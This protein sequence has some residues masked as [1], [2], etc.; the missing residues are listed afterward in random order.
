[1]KSAAAKKELSSA[2]RERLLTA[3]KARF[4]KN[5]N[6]HKGLDWAGVQAKLQANPKKL[7]SLQEME[8]TGGEPDVAT[9]DAQ[10]AS[11]SVLVNQGSGELAPPVS[12][13]VAESPLTLVAGD[14]NGDGRA[15][16]VTANGSGSVSVLTGD[17]EGGC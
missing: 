5:M 7:R 14:V 10:S 16:L 9:A 2:Q 4:E 15:D 12:H 11:V 8:R 1:M 13:A 6:R 17:G 3:L